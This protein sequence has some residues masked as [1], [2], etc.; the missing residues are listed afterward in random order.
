[1]PRLPAR[2]TNSWHLGDVIDD[3]TTVGCD[4]SHRSLRE[5]AA[6]RRLL[7]FVY[8]GCW[9]AFCL[10][11]L[12]EY[13]RLAPTFEALG[14]QLAALSVDLPEDAMRTFQRLRLPFPLQCDP[15]RAVI[16]PWGLL[17][18][19]DF[20]TAFPATFLFTADLRLEFISIDDSYATAK[21]DDVL[22]H[23]RALVRG[24]QPSNALRRVFRLPGV[25]DWLRG[26]RDEV[27]LRW[28]QIGARRSR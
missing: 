6:G 2:P 12:G 23:C 22:A 18:T 21:G 9:C 16:K 20:Q 27:R 4:G 7:L 5:L 26:W 25:R 3:V 14:V 11:R 24:E 1:M 17:N 15:E 8:R 19:D 28:R 13:R 10:H